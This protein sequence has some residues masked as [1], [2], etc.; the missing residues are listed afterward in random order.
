MIVILVATLAILA[1][2][3]AGLLY[4]HTHCANCRTELHGAPLCNHC[5]D[6]DD[7]DGPPD[8]PAG[9]PVPEAA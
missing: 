4:L 3:M 6:G 2:G 9:E 1:L 7:D 8:E 5:A